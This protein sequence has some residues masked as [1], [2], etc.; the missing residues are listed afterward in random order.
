MMSDAEAI[1]RTSGQPILRLAEPVPCGSV[2]LSRQE[3]VGF[4]ADFDPQLFHLDEGA[5]RS[6]IFGRLT[7]SGL[8]SGSSARRQV[9]DHVFARLDYRGVAGF[10]RMQMHKPVFPDMEVVVSHTVVACES[11]SDLDGLSLVKG[12]TTTHTPEGQLVMTLEDC[13][14]IGCGDDQ[15]PPDRLPPDDH[16]RLDQIFGA[17]PNCRAVAPLPPS[18]DGRIWYDDCVIGAGL[19]SSPYHVSQSLFASFDGDRQ[20]AEWLAICLNLRIFSDE[21]WLRTVNMGGPGIENVRVAHAVDPG[22]MLHGRLAISRLRRMRS[23]PDLG[24]VTAACQTFNQHDHLV[25][26]FEVTTFLRCKPS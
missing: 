14:W 7:A 19:E 11:F 20:R 16:P 5:A 26:S 23:R 6:S 15:A 8:Q 4:A 1:L 24:I 22:D 13:T 12:V 18:V 17:L 9:L 21:F 25:C 2:R 10:P 3:I